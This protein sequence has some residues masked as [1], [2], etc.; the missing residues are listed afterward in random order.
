MGVSGAGDGSGRGLTEQPGEQ[1]YKHHADQGNSAARH[2]L[3][4]ALAFCARVVVA[5]AFQQVDDAP[6]SEAGSQCDYEGLQ[7]VDCAVEKFHTLI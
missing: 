4:H 5:V 6:D 2:Q 7:N 1:R 3:F